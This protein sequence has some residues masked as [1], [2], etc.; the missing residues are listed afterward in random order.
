MILGLLNLVVFYIVF[1]A[2]WCL[3]INF[4]L[5]P[6]WVPWTSNFRLFWGWPC[7]L[8]PHNAGAAAAA[9]RI[10]LGAL[11]TGPSLRLQNNI[12]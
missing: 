12:T 11:A 10:E 3:A 2:S 8:A 7:S 6:F 4:K 9:G 5:S 1:T